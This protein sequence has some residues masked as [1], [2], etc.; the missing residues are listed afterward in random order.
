M[1]NMIL[2]EYIVISHRI[3]RDGGH[4]HGGGDDWADGSSGGVKE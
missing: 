3:V 1:R 2:V 4:H